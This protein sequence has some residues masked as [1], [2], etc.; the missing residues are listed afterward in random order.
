MGLGEAWG[1]DGGK[2]PETQGKYGFFLRCASHW[3]GGRD[4]LEISRRFKDVWE[5]HR[6]LIFIIQ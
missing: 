5:L 4:I 3:E 2:E 1:V 6:N